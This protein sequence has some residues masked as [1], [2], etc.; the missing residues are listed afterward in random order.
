MIQGI[1]RRLDSLGRIVIAKEIRKSL[2]IG[3][4]DP[5]ITSLKD[6]KIIIEPALGQCVICGTREGLCALCN[7]HRVCSCCMEHLNASI[8]EV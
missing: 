2:N 6:G 5:M 4:G 8:K 7:G 1:I 3:P